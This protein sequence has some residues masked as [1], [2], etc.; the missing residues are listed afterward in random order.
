[1]LFYIDK[2]IRLSSDCVCMKFKFFSLRSFAVK[3]VLQKKQTVIETGWP[4]SPGYSD[5]GIRP[6]AQTGSHL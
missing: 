2:I 6:A 3:K 1:M 4:E 5:D